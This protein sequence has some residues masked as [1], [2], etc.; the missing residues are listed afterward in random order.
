MKVS[1]AAK[2]DRGDK[3]KMGN[4]PVCPPALPHFDRDGN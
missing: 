1:Y 3:F 2:S 4:E